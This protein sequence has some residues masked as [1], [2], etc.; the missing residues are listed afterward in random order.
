VGHWEWG[1][2]RTHLAKFASR[3]TETDPFRP[4]CA[5]L[6]KKAKN[7]L[8]TRAAQKRVHVFAGT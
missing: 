1:N 4:V 7:G 3:H 8:L 5:F 6:L 2:W